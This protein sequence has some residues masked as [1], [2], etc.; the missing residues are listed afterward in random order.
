MENYIY[1]EEN[2]EDKTSEDEDLAGEEESLDSYEEDE[3]VEEC[4]ECGTAIRKE[5]R[6]VREVN[7]DEHIFCSKDCADE[8][9]ETLKEE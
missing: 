8:Y 2:T 6:M 4:A 3:K 1:E 9:E 7:G 5:K